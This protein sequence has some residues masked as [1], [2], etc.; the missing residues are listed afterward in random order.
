MPTGALV[1]M[2][3]T[4]RYMGPALF[5]RTTEAVRG[6]P[7]KETVSCRPCPVQ[8]RGTFDPWRGDAREAIQLLAVFAL[9]D[10]RPCTTRAQTCVSP[11]LLTMHNAI[12]PAGQL[13]HTSL[14]LLTVLHSSYE[15][16]V[17]YM[18]P[19]APTRPKRSRSANRSLLAHRD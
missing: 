7:P 14:E 15:P 10:P 18:P 5:S 8:P 3:C 13:F 12:S 16:S 4:H 11:V 19:L 9:L 2:P 6:S 1:P 17:P